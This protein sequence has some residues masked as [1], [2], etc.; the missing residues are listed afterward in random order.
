[1]RW[2]ST[3]ADWLTVQWYRMND[4]HDDGTEHRW[5][6]TD[7]FTARDFTHLVFYFHECRECGIEKV[8]SD[9]RV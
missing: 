1:M 3:V 8:D 9:P 7:R 5:R 2:L 4:R 6:M